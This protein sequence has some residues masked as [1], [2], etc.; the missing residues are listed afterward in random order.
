[1]NYF[2]NITGFFHGVIIAGLLLSLNGCGYKADP[3]YEEEV[4]PA[5]DA[6][7]AFHIKKQADENN[8]S[9]Q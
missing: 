6:N 9:C 7:V 1:M 4:A 5:G 8:E 2:Y 3:Y